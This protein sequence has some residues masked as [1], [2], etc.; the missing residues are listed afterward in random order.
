MTLQN[1]H[2]ATRAVHAGEDF[3][4]PTGDVNPPIHMSTVYRQAPGSDV[5]S[6]REYD[7][8]TGF[9]YTRWGN[10]TLRLFEQK[11]AALEGTD[12]AIAF[13]S[14]MAAT[15]GLLLGTLSQGDHLVLSNV[16]Y[17]GIAEYVRHQLPKFG[18]SASPVDTSDLAAVEAAIRPKTRLIFVDTPANPILRVSDIAAIAKIAHAHNASLAVDSTWASPIGTNPVEWGADYVM[19]SV[20]KYIGGHG[21]I[22]G[23]A[24]AGPADK[25]IPLRSAAGIY[26]GDGMAPELAWLA[27]R[28]L[29]TLPLRMRAHEAGATALAQFLESHPKVSRVLYPGLESHPQHDVAKKQMRNFSG[30]MAVRMK[31]GEAAAKRL[32]EN[33]SFV[34]PVVSLGKTKTLAY[35][36]STDQ[37][38]QNAFCMEGN[39][40]AKYTDLVGDGA[41]RISVGIEDPADIV[42]DFEQAL[43]RI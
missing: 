31:D 8:S 27:A 38:Q 40:L 4:Y 16:C 13:A 26:L 29:H 19:H 30:M 21:D 22:L 10:P 18:I 17:A 24:L 14:G 28:S 34:L 39:E 25:I 2:T 3:D 41:V 1:L 20:S 9:V 43:D 35:W 15:T 37:L 11:L 36:L 42:A 6:H 12:D 23:G 5:F 32:L 7:P 33:L